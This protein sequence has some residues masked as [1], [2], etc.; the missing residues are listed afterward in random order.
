MEVF[1]SWLLQERTSSSP[2]CDKLMWFSWLDLLLL[3][4]IPLL[5]LESSP[6]R[7][8]RNIRVIH[9]CQHAYVRICSACEPGSSVSDSSSHGSEANIMKT[10]LDNAFLDV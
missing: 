2:I 5:P 8:L 9:P 1:H 6:L 3:Q 10:D 7:W 4:L